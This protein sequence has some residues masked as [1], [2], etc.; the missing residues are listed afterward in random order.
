MHFARQWAI[1]S[2]VA[3]CAMLTVLAVWLLIHLG[4]DNEA[5]SQIWSYFTNLRLVFL[6]V[7]LST[8][9]GLIETIIMMLWY[10]TRTRESMRG[11]R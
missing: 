2:G 7:V 1:A 4:F 9:I 8:L 5:V 6:A 11:L 3:L 10:R